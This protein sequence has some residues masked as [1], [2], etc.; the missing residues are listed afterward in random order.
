[1]AKKTPPVILPR[2]PSDDE[3]R[4]RFVSGESSQEPKR[5][6]AA[7]PRRSVSREPKRSGYRQLYTRADGRDVRKV[8]IYFTAATAKQ[9]AVFCANEDRDMSTVVDEVVAKALSKQG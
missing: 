1:M 4:D 3:A 2:K 8:S 9:L 5:T 7:A 6:N